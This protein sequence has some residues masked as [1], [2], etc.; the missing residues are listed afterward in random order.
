MNTSI[1]EPNKWI[2]IKSCERK[3]LM[4]TNVS[5]GFSLIKVFLP[6][7][8]IFGMAITILCTFSSG[9]SLQL[10]AIP[11]IMSLIPCIIFIVSLISIR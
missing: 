10:L 7:T 2:P 11:F 3:Q 5:M 6:S 1:L 9:F 4:R 8:F